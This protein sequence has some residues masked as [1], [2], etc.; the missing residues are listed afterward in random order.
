MRSY[1]R[2][3]LVTV[4]AVAMT[5]GT[6]AVA[7][8]AMSATWSPRTS[9]SFDPHRDLTE[10]ES[11]ILVE[12]NQVRTERGLPKVRVFHSCVDT[13]AESWARRLGR[14]GSFHHRDLSTV[15]E[16]CDLN[17]VG[18]NLVRGSDLLPRTAVQAWMASPAH[19]SVLLKPRARWAGIGVRVGSDGKK[20]AVLN[21]GDRS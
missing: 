5:A 8:P 18:E 1:V 14:T 17:W 20:Y 11:R 6:A 12:V 13:Y 9:S 19:R 10:F 4:L 16:G 21:F 15:L 2:L 7:L 3:I